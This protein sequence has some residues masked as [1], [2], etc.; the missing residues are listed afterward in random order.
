MKITRRNFIKILGATGLAVAVPKLVL[1]DEAAIVKEHE[2]FVR[3][4]LGDLKPGDYVFSYWYRKRGQQSI[5]R[6]VRHV[7]VIEGTRLQ[8]G[9][10]MCVGDSVGMFQLCPANRTNINYLP[11]SAPVEQDHSGSFTAQY[12][13]SVMDVIITAV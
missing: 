8:V 7:T 10:D 12:D 5:T 6:Y 3:Y 13:A 11:W 1:D 4:T 9:V 2:H